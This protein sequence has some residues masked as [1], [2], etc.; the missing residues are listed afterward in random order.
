LQSNKAG[1]VVGAC[2]LI[3]S[4]GSLTLLELIGKKAQK[5][6]IVQNV[7]IEVNIGNEPNK[8][9]VLPEQTAEI[10][11]AASEIRGVNILGLMAIPP[12]LEEFGGNSH[13]FDAMFKLFVDM[14]GKKYDNVSMRL[15][16]MGMSDSF[17]EAIRAGANMVR[18]GSAIFGTRF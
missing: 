3:E 1:K 18:I 17:A 13:Y 7:L 10:L 5:L 16:S 8:S 15:L 9:G 14:S 12:I 2:A 11:G 4:V 6:E